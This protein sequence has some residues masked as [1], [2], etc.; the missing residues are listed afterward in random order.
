MSDEA[1]KYRNERVAFGKLQQDSLEYQVG[2]RSEY[3]PELPDDEA[4]EEKGYL[5]K[6]NTREVESDGS[7]GSNDI[8]SEYLSANYGSGR[9]VSK[10]S[11]R[12]SEVSLL[13][14]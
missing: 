8:S 13:A 11:S 7:F 4:E 9:Q 6:R 5:P 12:E 14:I 2:D 3:L 1:D 10:I